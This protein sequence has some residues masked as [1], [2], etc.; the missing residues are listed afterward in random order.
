M[1]IARDMFIQAVQS[2]RLVR[3]QEKVFSSTHVKITARVAADPTKSGVRLYCSGELSCRLVLAAENIEEADYYFERKSLEAFITGLSD[4]YVEITKDGGRSILSSG[5]RRVEFIDPVDH[6]K[7]PTRP[8]SKLESLGMLSEPDAEFVQFCAKI[9]P[10]TR[11]SPELACVWAEPSGDGST[12]YATNDTGLLV[13]RI[14]KKLTQSIAL[15]RALAQIARFGTLL[16]S[17]REVG[18]EN[19]YGLFWTPA[20][21]EAQKNFPLKRCKQVLARES[22]LIFEAEGRDMQRAFD[23]LK[24]AFGSYET[25]SDTYFLVEGGVC[26]IRCRFASTRFE[27]TIGVSGASPE[28]IIYRLPLREFQALLPMFSKQDV[29]HVYNVNDKNVKFEGDRFQLVIPRY[30]AKR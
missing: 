11:V 9:T 2:L 8:K 28:R 17:D 23:L 3:E 22:S 1:K 29:M 13:A 24:D 15:P 21:V 10:S 20:P 25:G 19:T 7:F 6:H 27:E 16:A 18:L 12:L 30:A 14:D 5:N 26:R 4:D